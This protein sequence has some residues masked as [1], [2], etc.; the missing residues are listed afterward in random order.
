LICVK[1]TGIAESFSLTPS[2][3]QK[4]LENEVTEQVLGLLFLENRDDL[5]DH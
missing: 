2:S 3:P 1:C 4:Q 5:K